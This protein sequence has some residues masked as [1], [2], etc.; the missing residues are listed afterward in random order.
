MARTEL[1][2]ID[3]SIQSAV[4]WLTSKGRQPGSAMLAAIVDAAA[5]EVVTRR[6]AVCAELRQRIVA[7]DGRAREEL[8]AIADA[9]FAELRTAVGAGARAA[10][11]VAAVVFAFDQL[12]RDPDASEYLDDP[13]Y[14]EG[15]RLEI[16]ARIDR[17]NLVIRSYD[18]FVDVLT[19]LLRSRGTTRVLD[20]AAGHGGFCLAAARV[21]SARGL[22]LHFTATDLKPE[23]LELG[24]ERARAEGLPIDFASQDALDLSNLDPGA[25]DIIT[26]TQTLHHFSPGLVAVMFEEASRVAGRGVVFLDACRSLIAGLGLAAFGALRL[27]HLPFTHDSWVSARRFYLPEELSM[28]A[29]LGPW[30]DDV[31]SVWVEP[32]HCLLRLAL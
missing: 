20:L 26:C 16:M 25:Y 28:L 22:D 14:D 23:Y 15:V 2:S 21:A 1:D 24:A 29:R 17:L 32:G 18:G 27:R 6:R 11:P 8:A 13:D 31:E 12:W 3:R 4:D 10:G 30:G 7:G 19:P 5:D 9:A